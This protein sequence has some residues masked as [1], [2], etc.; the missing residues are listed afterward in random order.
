MKTFTLKIAT[1]LLLFFVLKVG[2]L[3][4]LQKQEAPFQHFFMDSYVEGTFHHSME[5]ILEHVTSA[6]IPLIQIT[7][8]IDAEKIK[9]KNI[10]FLNSHRQLQSLWQ[11]SYNEPDKKYF[12]WH[13]QREG[14][15]G[16]SS[17]ENL[18]TK[19]TDQSEFDFPQNGQTLQSLVYMLQFMDFSSTEPISFEILTP[20]KQF[21][22]MYAK[23]IGTDVLPFEGK[24]TACYKV[25]VGLRGL[26]GVI[27][28]SLTF[29]IR[30]EEPHLP[31]QYKDRALLVKLRTQ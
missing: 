26:L 10:S 23:T 8:I 4:A 25:E 7:T 20:P 28:P 9:E 13:L 24:N 5:I 14:L 15:K 29:W 11:V 6:N 30:Q 1:L 12:E 16:N 22:S 31:L 2:T 27:S 19:N 3:S 18:L 21:F 17:F